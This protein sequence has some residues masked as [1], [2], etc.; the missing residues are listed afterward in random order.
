MSLVI[1]T[2]LGII[3]L[4][5]E[6]DTAPLTVQHATSVAEAG[7]FNDVQFYRSDFVIQMGTAHSP[8]REVPKIS[9]NEAGLRKCRTNARGTAAFAHWDV[10]D[11]GAGDFFI[12]TGDNPHLDSAYGGFCVFAAVADAD[13]ASLRV[14]DAVAES[15]KQGRKVAVHEV[16]H[17]ATAAGEGMG[18]EEP[19]LQPP[20]PQSEL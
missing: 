13:A 9:A 19:E 5:L 2:A 12:N 10:P 7:T 15:V 8:G 18:K 1:K 16:T 17:E 4:V 6:R 11:A 14:V 20:E 3:T